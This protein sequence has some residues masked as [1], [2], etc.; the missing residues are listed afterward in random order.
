MEN[1]I[2]N[3]EHHVKR[4]VLM[5]LNRTHFQ[6]NAAVE[7]GISERCI[8][9]YKKQFNISY[10]KKKDEFYFRGERAVLIQS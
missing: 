5:A 6:K 7:L 8:H 1:E 4:L 10:D 3:I 2:L 9:R